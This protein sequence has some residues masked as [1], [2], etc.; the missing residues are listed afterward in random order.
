MI[1]F[2]IRQARESIGQSLGQG[3][4]CDGPGNQAGVHGQPPTRLSASS[5]ASTLADHRT[6][7]AIDASSNQLTVEK[8]TGELA[9]Y[10]PR[11][12]TGVNVFKEVALEF[13]TSDRIQ[14]TAPDKALGVANRGLAVIE[15]ISPEGRVVAR[16]EDHRLIEFDPNE[17][18]HFDHGYAVT[19]HNARGLTAERVLVNAETGVHPNL[20]NSRFGYVSILCASHEAT[21]F[22]DNMA[23]LK[24]Q[25]VTDISKT[26]ALDVSRRSN[27]AHSIEIA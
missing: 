14:F 13:S 4:H 5:V 20:L 12:H 11:R 9:T 19:I 7:V 21:V 15:S 6:P 1:D 18:R 23:K 26:T 22:T 24:P 2:Q 27:I 3:S 8:S 16:R 17:H 10:D 25:L